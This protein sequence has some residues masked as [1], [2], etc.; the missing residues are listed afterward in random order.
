MASTSSTPIGC[1]AE[2][3]PSV[4]II[5]DEPVLRASVV[6]GLAKLPELDV[7]DC[8]T[9]GEALV[10]IDA[11]PPDLGRLR[12]RPARLQRRRVAG[13]VGASQPQHTHPLRIGLSEGLPGA[14][15]LHANVEV[16]EKPVPLD[17]LRRR[18]TDRLRVS[19]TPR[20][21]FTVIDY[22]QL[23]CMGRHS[24]RIDVA[25]GGGASASV[26]VVNGE[27]WS[28]RDEKGVG[29]DAFCRFAFRKEARA[30]CRAL[31]SDPGPRD[32][33]VGW[34]AL[35]ME[36]ARM[37]DEGE[38]LKGPSP[39]ES[40]ASEDFGADLDFE[41]PPAAPSAPPIQATDD[42]ATERA[43]KRLLDDEVEALLSK[44]FS[45]ALEAFGAAHELRPG[46]PVVTAN[47][48]RLAE[49]GHGRGRTGE[50][51]K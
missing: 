30:D 1:P 14:D 42:G 2:P 48:K 38:R 4:L 18:V 49:L 50:E 45:D 40:P 20:A 44:R 23:A 33:Q 41:S 47:L 8:G 21:P 16:L 28:A 34:E 5:E 19:A 3:M 12:H 32:I 17:E 22:L 46:D 27:I 31:D 29:V 13:R 15:P 24:L 6:R 35:L 51:K 43:F 36:A 39:P 26:L 37:F 25:L 9:L 11:T 7:F 10:I